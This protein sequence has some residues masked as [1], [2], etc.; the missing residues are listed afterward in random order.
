MTL[1]NRRLVNRGIAASVIALLVTCSQSA[2]SQSARTIRVVVPFP[3]GGSA[4]ILAR[5]L[6]EQ[7]NKT[8]GPTVVIENRPGGGATIAYE[9]VMRAPPDGNTLVINGN[10]LVIN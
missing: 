10:S 2:W 3:P 5:V 1:P 6:G 9:A 7:I 8:N 4:D